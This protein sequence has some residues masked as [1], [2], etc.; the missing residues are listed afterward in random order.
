MMIKSQD[1]QLD[2]NI[3]ALD[4]PVGGAVVAIK[5]NKVVY[6]KGFGKARL[7]ADEKPFTP[8]TIVSIM[9]ISKS[10]T[11][12]SLLKLV[13]EGLLELDMP[14]VHYLPYFQTTD[15]EVSK[16][17]TVRHLLSHTAGFAGDLGIGDLVSPIAFN[18]RDFEKMKEQCGVTDSII[19][20]IRTRE[21][22]TRYIRSVALSD[23]PGSNWSYCTDAYIV[24]ADLFE[25]VS[26]S[27]WDEFMESTWFRGLGLNRTTLYAHKVQQ[28]EDHAMYYTSNDNVFRDATRPDSSMMAYEIPFLVNQLGAPMGFIYSTAHDLGSYLSSYM[29]EHPFLSS[30]ALHEMFETVWDFEE[31]GEGYALG[32]G[33]NRKENLLI[34]EHGGGYTGVS[35]YVCMVPSHGT[36]VIVVSNHD[37]TPSQKIA[38]EMLDLLLQAR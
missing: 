25:Q 1:T 19:G 35:A 36:A 27:S 6:S 14:I 37:E 2:F 28:A 12:A 17:I 21:D 18:L 9:S 29:N 11:A 34:L 23:T 7:G 15:E 8:D 5:D 13:D 32:W 26:G 30:Y 20:G 10:F 31:E 33:T 38:Y 22:V 3:N 4:F 24:A 16:R